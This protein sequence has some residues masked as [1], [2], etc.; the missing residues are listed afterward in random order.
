MKKIKK[1]TKREEPL[2]QWT[3]YQGAY[4]RIWSTHPPQDY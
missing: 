2:I 3:C 1:L 4:Q